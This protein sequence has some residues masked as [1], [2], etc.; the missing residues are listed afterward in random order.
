M[1]IQL[2][3]IRNEFNIHYISNKN[4][5]NYREN[6]YAKLWTKKKKRKIK[7][8]VKIKENILFI[9]FSKI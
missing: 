3:Y 9:G 5:L 1:K 7:V 2:I 4:I 8:Y 6:W